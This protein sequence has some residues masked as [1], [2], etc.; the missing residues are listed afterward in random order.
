MIKIAN[1]RATLSPELIAVSQ[2]T[3]RRKIAN[4][5]SYLGTITPYNKECS[6]KNAKG[7]LMNAGR[8]VR[9]PEVWDDIT[10]R[11]RCLEYTQFDVV[12]ERYRNWDHNLVT[13]PLLH[14]QTKNVVID[15]TWLLGPY[16]VYVPVADIL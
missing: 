15:K 1:P 7:L 14:S 6:L 10:T 5:Q 3:A 4:F 13:G 9:T 16:D 2:A 8:M 11:L 12:E